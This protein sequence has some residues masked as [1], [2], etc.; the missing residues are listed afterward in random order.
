MASVPHKQLGVFDGVCIIVGIIIGAGIYETAPAV[1]SGAGSG[2][3]TLGIWLLG[4]LLALAGALCY[5]MLATAFT[6][7]GGDYVYLSRAYGR[8]T[9]F[10]FGWSQ[11]LVIRPGDIALMAYIFARYATQIYPFPYCGRLYAVGTIGLL[12]VLNLLGVQQGKWTQN[13][14]TVLK[15]LGLG[16]IFAAALWAP[17]QSITES[18]GQVSGAGL[19]LAFILVL[20]TYGGWNEIAYVAAEVTNPGKNILRTLLIGV[21]TVTVVYLLANLA[22]LRTLGYAGVA[23]S[24]AVA[25]DAMERVFPGGASRMI[26]ALICVSALGAMNGLI[27]TGARI[28][29]ALG[30]DHRLFGLLGHWKSSSAGP[31]R[32]L[33]L[34]GGLSLLVALVAGSFIDTILYTAP[35]VWLFFLGTGFSVFVLR[36]KSPS[37]FPIVGPIRSRV[38]P[39]LFC[40]TCLFMLGN[41]VHYAFIHKPAAL[42]L[43]AVLLATGAI[44]YILTAKIKDW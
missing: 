3:A 15:V 8:G 6:E 40:G 35:A 36:K 21:V 38:V 14:L 13:I 5:A 24:Q 37:T 19:Q 27:F 7:Q 2:P 33:V 10:L 18:T 39:V 30:Q 12:T 31:V 29:Y 4:G 32:A 1:A 23:G 41:C 9:G 11:L 20:F 22:F 43:L 28:S 42:G 34:Q 44:V 25:A 17:Q 16:A 26:A